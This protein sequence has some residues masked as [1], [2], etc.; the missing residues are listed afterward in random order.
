MSK[1]K[2]YSG[3]FLRKV[4]AI[5]GV[6]YPSNIYTT[7]AGLKIGKCPLIFSDFR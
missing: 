7:R 3:I 2:Y 4:E 1:D 5:A 6:Y